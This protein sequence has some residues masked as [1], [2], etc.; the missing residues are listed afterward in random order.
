MISNNVIYSFDKYIKEF[1]CLQP[2]VEQC[3]EIFIGYK[4]GPCI[5]YLTPLAASCY[6]S[7]ICRQYLEHTTVTNFT[8]Y[9]SVSFTSVEYI[10]KPVTD[11]CDKV[12]CLYDLLNIN[13]VLSCF[14]EKKYN[15]TVSITLTVDV[16]FD[17]LNC[18]GFTLAWDWMGLYVYSKWIESMK[19]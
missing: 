7:S 12:S 10:L 6:L 4:W 9:D 16:T 15:E 19:K 1:C 5:W 8:S 2:P 13:K 18:C 3:W 17:C 11:L 14:N